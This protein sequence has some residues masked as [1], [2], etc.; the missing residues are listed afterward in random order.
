MIDQML[1]KNA[2][3]FENIELDVQLKQIITVEEKGKVT[4]VFYS[5]TTKSD[6]RKNYLV[7]DAKGRI[8]FNRAMFS[9]GCTKNNY[10]KWLNKLIEEKIMM[11]ISINAQGFIRYIKVLE[12]E[13]KE[14]V[15]KSLLLDTI[16]GL[17]DSD[18]ELLMSLNLETI[19]KE[20]GH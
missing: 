13:K 15:L 12:K 14:V 7:D 18:R 10:D 6:Y 8:D 20:F 16:D 11:K 2:K 5:P 9:V 1:A 19:K 4:L 17:G 3:A